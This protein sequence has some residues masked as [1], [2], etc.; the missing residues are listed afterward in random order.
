[1]SQRSGTV[2]TV[3]GPIEPEQLGITLT[4]EHLL[5][6]LRLPRAR[7]DAGA[8]ISLETS[9]RNRRH[10][11]EN[12]NNSLLADVAL[13]VSELGEFKQ[14]GGGANISRCTRDSGL[15]PRIR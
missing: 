11:S 13:A 10:S 6:D 15:G 5:L 7:S 12:P 8:E 2:Q 1:M 4:H 3:L 9:G 14:A